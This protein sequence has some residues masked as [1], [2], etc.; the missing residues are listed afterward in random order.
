[1][2]KWYLIFA[3]IKWGHLT[4]ASIAKPVHMHACTHKYKITHIIYH[5]PDCEA[6]LTVLRNSFCVW[7]E[8]Y[9]IIPSPLAVLNVNTAS[10]VHTNTHSDP[11]PLPV[12]SIASQ[13][14]CNQARHSWLWAGLSSESDLYLL[15]AVKPHLRHERKRPIYTGDVT[16]VNVYRRAYLCVKGEALLMFDTRS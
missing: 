9:L 2:S 5:D 10:Q 4:L 12:P 6:H 7:H 11:S 16:G 15:R 3:Y 1:M 8:L 13:W 14:H